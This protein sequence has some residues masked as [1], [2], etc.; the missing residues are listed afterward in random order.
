[1]VSNSIMSLFLTVGAIFAF[2]TLAVCVLMLAAY[3]MAKDGTKTA[4]RAIEKFFGS[5]CRVSTRDHTVTVRQ[6]VAVLELATARGEFE[7]NYSWHRGNRRFLG[8][9]LPF[10][11]KAAVCR[12]EYVVK[13]GFD[14]KEKFC[15]FDFIPVGGQA[16]IAKILEGRCYHVRVK[17]P[18]PQIL[19]LETRNVNVE[20]SA[21]WYDFWNG[22]NNGDRNSIMSEMFTEARNHVADV[23]GPLLNEAQQ[24]LEGGLRAIMPAHVKNIEFEWLDNPRAFDFECRGGNNG[25]SKVQEEC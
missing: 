22:L 13:A 8:L 9:P 2:G 10:T 20:D 5:G 12:H 1:M 4:C 18:G 24:R 14:L 7:H 15:V 3:L 19:S 25:I 23:G 11:A 16:F 6:V 21:C 17:I